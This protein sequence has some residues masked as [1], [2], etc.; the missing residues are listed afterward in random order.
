MAKKKAASRSSGQNGTWHGFVRIYLGEVD[1]KHIVDS[2]ESGGNVLL[3][4][5]ELLEMGYSFKIAWDSYSN[6]PTV[7][8]FGGED[9]GENAGWGMSARHSDLGRAVHALLYQHRTFSDENGVWLK[10]TDINSENDW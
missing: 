10:P 6:C 3:D 1:K 8:M 5:S 7:M 4:M 9:S 2:H